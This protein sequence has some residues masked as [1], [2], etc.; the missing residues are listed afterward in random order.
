MKTFSKQNL[1]DLKR[2]IQAAI[3]SVAMKHDVHLKMGR[4]VYSFNNATIKIQASVKDESG[5][6]I[7]KTEEDFKKY[8]DSY[9]LSKEDLG[10]TI[11]IYD[12]LHRITGLR[13]KASKRPIII[14]NVETGKEYVCS[15]GEV[16]RALEMKTW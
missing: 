9:D 1:P 5:N 4:A 11:E 2:D 6:V 12:S 8:A 13:I 15:A 10:K 3:E 7:K 16:K 14:E